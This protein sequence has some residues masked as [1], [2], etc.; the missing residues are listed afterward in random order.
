MSLLQKIPHR[1]SLE[2]RHSL[3]I[4]FIIGSQ[5][6]QSLLIQLFCLPVAGGNKYM[7]VGEKN[8]VKQNYIAEYFVEKLNY[9]NRIQSESGMTRQL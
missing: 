9:K 8:S 2:T 1:R 4:T 6:V 5:Q 3:L 7:H